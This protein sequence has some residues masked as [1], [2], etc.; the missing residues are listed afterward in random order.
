VFEI[1]T[2]KQN[3]RVPPRLW[4]KNIKLA[5]KSALSELEGKMSKMH[6]ILLAV[7]D[8]QEVGEGK[9]LPGDGAVYFPT[10]FEALVF[11]PELNEVV[12]SEVMD[13][14][15]FGSFLRVGA[16]DGLVHVSQISD[17][18]FSYSKE[19]VM[20]GKQSKKM[21][22]IGDKVRA[23]IIS[24]SYKAEPTKLGLTMRQP[25]LGKWEWLEGEEKNGKQE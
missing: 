17:D 19:G 9:I 22:K 14:T 23:R 21:I 2:I 18:F 25:D 8:I 3:V 5:V 12:D 16:L 15:E 20:Q 7:T 6:G 1:V 24:V 10:Q 13:M 11:R 4:K